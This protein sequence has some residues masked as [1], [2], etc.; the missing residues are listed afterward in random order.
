MQKKEKLC[1]K[2]C[3]KNINLT[4]QVNIIMVFRAIY[5]KWNVVH[6]SVYVIGNITTLHS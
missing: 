6:F 4:A 2:K 3:R 1:S 5:I